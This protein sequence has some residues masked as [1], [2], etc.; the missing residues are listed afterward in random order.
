[1]LLNF[2]ALAACYEKRMDQVQTWRHDEPSW[3]TEEIRADARVY[4]AFLGEM[5]YPLAPIEQ[6]IISD[7]PYTPQAAPQPPRTPTTRTRTRNASP[8]GPP[9]SREGRAR[10]PDCATDLSGARRPR[11]GRRPGRPTVGPAHR[12]PGARRARPPPRPMP[13]G[14]PR[15]PD[16][17]LPATGCGRVTTP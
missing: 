17:R 2:A 13:P 5:G 8:P 10:A 11:T 1:M 14:R 15:R 3:D 12:V 9:R 16:C 6:A 7:E 4:L